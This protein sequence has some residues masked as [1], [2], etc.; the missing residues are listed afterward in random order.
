MHHR[1]LPASCCNL[2]PTLCAIYLMRW[3]L[4]VRMFCRQQLQ[5]ALSAVE[6]GLSSL[7]SSERCDAHAGHFSSS[8]SS[9]RGLPH[10]YDVLLHR[11]KAQLLLALSRAN[12]ALAVLGTAR[13][14]L[15][16]GRRA[17]GSRQDAAAAVALLRQEEA[18][19]CKA[20][21]YCTA[22]ALMLIQWRP[23]RWTAHSFCKQVDGCTVIVF[24]LSTRLYWLHCTNTASQQ[25]RWLP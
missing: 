12:E 7:P 11:V 5:P 20:C 17:L 15:A 9:S 8:S 24:Y 19:V 2:H 16:A 10:C 18:Q 13:Q 21:N 4:L 3:P 6:A 22:N 25:S 23:N 14:R 1:S